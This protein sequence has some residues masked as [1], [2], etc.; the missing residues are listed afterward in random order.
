MFRFLGWLFPAWVLLATATR[1]FAD[2]GMVLLHQESAPFVVTLFG[3]P[4]PLR[5][6][7]VDL[8]VLLQSS[9]TMEPVLD[10]DVD[11]I[12]T[13]GDSDIGV[14]ATRAQAQNKL[15]YAASV[16]LAA[17]QWSYR[18]WVGGAHEPSAP[19]VIPGVMVV[20]AAQPKLAAYGTYLALPFVCLA[21]FALHQWLRSRRRE[22]IGS[23]AIWT[24]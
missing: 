18:I 24:A 3:S 22:Q 4:A 21:I 2:G 20:D 11:F 9:E 17:G 16:R 23:T 6:G 10:R 19:V 15:L 5:A 7:A 13:N 8:T 12:L 1:L 14:R